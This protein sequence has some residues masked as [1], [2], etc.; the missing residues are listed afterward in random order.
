MRNF[1][2]N[3]LQRLEINFYKFNGNGN[4]KRPVPELPKSGLRFESLSPDNS[5]STI[6]ESKTQ[7]DIAI[8]RA[9]QYILGEQ[10]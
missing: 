6:L 4:G 9:Q 8:S 10:V 2:T 7:I 1:F 5:H 3:F